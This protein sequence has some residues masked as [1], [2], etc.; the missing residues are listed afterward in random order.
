MS[1]PA[2]LPEEPKFSVCLMCR[3]TGLTAL[4]R[5]GCNGKPS[6]RIAAPRP[7]SKNLILHAAPRKAARMRM[8]A[9]RATSGQECGRRRR[10]GGSWCP[11]GS[12]SNTLEKLEL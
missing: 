3:F 2:W 11:G 4:L 9:G 10:G 5:L 7:N 12:E 8:E 6:L 1:D